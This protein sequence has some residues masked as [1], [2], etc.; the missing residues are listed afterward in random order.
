M[1]RLPLRAVK[2]VGMDSHAIDSLRY[3]R[4]T[5]ERAGSFTA[6]PGWGGVAMGVMGLAAGFVAAG[7]LRPEERL[8][9][10]MVTGVVAMAVGL[11]SMWRKARRAEAPALVAPMRKFVLSFAPP[12]LAGALLTAALFQANLDAAV[13]GTWL[14]LY[15]TG[16]VAGGAFSVRPV[17]VMGFCF[18]ALGG[19][20]LFSPPAWGNWWLAGGF[21]GLHVFFGAWIARRY[22]G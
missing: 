20:A 2:T 10:W 3:I 6:V 1:H 13:P 7:M 22:G 16:V 21:G 5:M 4:E 14:L 8:A 18:M 15:G 19:A 12:L 9:A 11:A 17:P